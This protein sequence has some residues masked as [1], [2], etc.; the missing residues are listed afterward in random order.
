MRALA[1][2]LI[3]RFGKEITYTKEEVG[4]T[5]DPATGKNSGGS[6]SSFTIKVSP[7]DP[8]DISLVDG[9]II[10]AGDARCLVAARA[11]EDLG[12]IPDSITD[13]LDFGGAIWTVVGVKHIWSGDQVAAFELQVRKN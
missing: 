5:Y 8:Y 1:L 3:D 12:L 10:R 4:A 9:E 2:D 6:T 7:P 13:K 11:A